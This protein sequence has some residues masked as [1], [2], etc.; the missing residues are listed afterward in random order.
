MDFLVTYDI[1][2]A[3]KAGVRRLTRVAHLCEGY[4]LRVQNSVFECRLSSAAYA[5]LLVDLADLVIPDEDSVNIYRF[6]GSL[7]EIRLSIGR[8]PLV[9]PTTSWLV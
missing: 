9:D 5:Q 3:D 7:R 2:T 4:G 6:P 8:L 1:A